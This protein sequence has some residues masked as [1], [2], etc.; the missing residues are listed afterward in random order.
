MQIKKAADLS[1]RDVMKLERPAYAAAIAQGELRSSASAYLHNAA[2]LLD[3][4]PT[5][6]QPINIDDLVDRVKEAQLFVVPDGSYRPSSPLVVWETGTHHTNGGQWRVT[7]DLPNKRLGQ[8]VAAMNDWHLTPEEAHSVGPGARGSLS[9]SDFDLTMRWQQAEELE[10]SRMDA[11]VNRTPPATAVAAAIAAPAPITA[12]K[13]PLEQNPRRVHLEVGIFTDGTL[14]NAENTAEFRRQAVKRCISAYQNG[15][16]NK[17]ECR[18][19]LMLE[20]GGSYGNAPSNVAKL[21]DLYI[22]SEE[23]SDTSITH[24]LRVY[25]PGAGS[26]TGGDDS[27]RD[28]TTG[29]GETGV[30]EQV[31][32]AFERL[33]LSV[34]RLPEREF[35]QLTIDLF[36][37]SRGAAAARHA[38][39]EINKGREGQL[40]QLLAQQ[41]LSWPD[42][43]SIRFM[44]LF[45]TVAGIVNFS[46][47]DFSA[48]ND[49]N[50]PVRTFI[51]PNKVENVVHLTAQHERRENF[52]LNSIC[53]PDG[54]L[55]AHFREIA[56]PGAHSDIGGGYSNE[57]REEVFLSP[58]IT[59]ANRS[60]QWPKQTIEWDELIQLKRHTETERWIGPNSLPVKVADT[61]ISDHDDTQEMRAGDLR[62]VAETSEHPAPYGRVRMA[63]KMTR[64]LRGEYSRIS[65]RIMHQL[66]KEAGVTFDDV[67][68][69]D[70]TTSLPTELKPIS[71]RLISQIL[72]GTDL[73]SLSHGQQELLIQR[74][75]HHSDHYNLTEF[76]MMGQIGGLEIPVDLLRPFK[77][78]LSGDRLIHPNVQEEAK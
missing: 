76:L 26:K 21:R 1:I 37:F 58:I 23:R 4:G 2:E 57:Q 67:D 9:A 12:A 25:S 51:D 65:L 72:T 48:S 63:L 10:K 60:A 49:N 17:D 56:L 13:V 15:E 19:K 24:R 39:G 41:G 45:D 14:N 35:H 78:S 34:S 29:L 43:V 55:P 74:Y 64:Y 69:T 77:P 8:I 36:G 62:I 52:P 50:T 6:R 22:E 28:M 38:A 7:G 68:A 61:L 18:R 3:I 27:L 47:G 33:A 53:Y 5:F 59:L 32:L 71:D 54:S 16:I 73:P 42:K 20:M 11:D 75:I 46:E 40:G 31:K 70:S 66:G 44:G 30:I